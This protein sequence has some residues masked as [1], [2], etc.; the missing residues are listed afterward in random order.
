MYSTL[1]ITLI[2]LGGAA[3]T[4][5]GRAILPRWAFYLV[6]GA[7][8]FAASGLWWYGLL[9]AVGSILWLSKGWGEG[10]SAITGRMS[11]NLGSNPLIEKVCFKLVPDPYATPDAAKQWG[12]Y[13]MLQRGLYFLYPIF[14]VLTL[15]TGNGAFLVLGLFSGLQGVCYR[16]FGFVPEGSNSVACAEVLMGGVLGLLMVTG[17]LALHGFS[18]Y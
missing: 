2:L 5:R 6:M 4:L 12:F 7:L 3:N 15:L 17:V 14:I 9:W 8:A 16:M 18:P 13:F 11:A 10:F 1:A